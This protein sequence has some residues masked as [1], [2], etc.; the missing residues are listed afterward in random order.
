LVAFLSPDLYKQFYSIAKE[1]AGNNTFNK[2]DEYNLIVE[3]DIFNKIKEF[4]PINNYGNNKNNRGFRISKNGKDTGIFQKKDEQNNLS[5]NNNNRINIINDQNI[6]P[7]DNPQI[8]NNI[9]SGVIH[10]VPKNKI[11]EDN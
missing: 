1:Q 9:S 5:F 8:P 10:I 11:E 4:S 3:K 2:W 7:F 6:N